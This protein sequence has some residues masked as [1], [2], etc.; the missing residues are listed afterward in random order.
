MPAHRTTTITASSIT[1]NRTTG[2]ILRKSNRPHQEPERAECLD[3]GLYGPVDCAPLLEFKSLRARP[4]EDCGLA[5]LT[6]RWRQAGPLLSRSRPGRTRSSGAV[7]V[8]VNRRPDLSTS[9]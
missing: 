5:Q 3:A 6:Q 1:T 7:M 9:W 8:P 2:Q 4:D